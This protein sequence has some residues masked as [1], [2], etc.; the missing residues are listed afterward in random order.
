MVEM[1]NS[2]PVHDTI[3]NHTKIGVHA[4]VEIKSLIPLSKTHLRCACLCANNC[5]EIEQEFKDGNTT[6]DE[7][8]ALKLG[9]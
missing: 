1:K 9:L 5:K 6:R 8:E 2:K 4:D 3:T 7:N